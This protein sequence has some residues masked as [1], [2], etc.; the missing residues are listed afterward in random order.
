MRGIKATEEL[1]GILD[2]W[3]ERHKEYAEIYHKWTDNSGKIHIGIDGSINLE[4]LAEYIAKR[5]EK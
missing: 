4:D 2:D 3:F 5:Q 1:I